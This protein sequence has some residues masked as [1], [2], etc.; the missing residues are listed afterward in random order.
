MDF[1]K[2]IDNK[3]MLQGQMQKQALQRLQGRDL[4]SLAAGKT[5]EEQRVALRKAAEE[6]EAIFAYQMIVAMRSTVGDGGMV[7]KSNGEKIFESMLDEE[8]AKK[9]SSQTGSQ[10]LA[11]A[12]YRQLGRQLGVETGALPQKDEGGFM[13][14]APDSPPVLPLREQTNIP[15]QRGSAQ[16]LPLSPAERGAS[17]E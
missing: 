3:T 5:V 13:Q 7:E 11:N 14:L 1:A 8:W 17:H 10:G 2:L 9:L 4:E 12:I 16:P 15:L 6:F